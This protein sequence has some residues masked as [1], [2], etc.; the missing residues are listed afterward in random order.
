MTTDEFI[1]QWLDSRDFI[2][3]HTSGSTGAPKA[4][5]LAKADMRASARATNGFFGLTEGSLFV[6]PLSPDYIAGKM[7]IVRA[8]EAGGEI[9]MLPPSNHFEMPEADVALLAIVPSQVPWLLERGDSARVRNII[10]GGAKLDDSMRRALVDAG[11]NAYETYG[12]TETCSHVALRHVSGEVFS[13]MPGVTFSTDARGC[14]EI[15]IPNMSVK[16]VVTND[17]VELHSEKEFRWLGR[18]DNV[19]NSGGIKIFPEELEERIARLVP[20]EVCGEFYIVGRRHDVWGECVCMVFV[21]D[22]STAD[23]IARRLSAGL[24]HTHVPKVYE[25]VDALPRTSNGKIIRR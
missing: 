4:V 10:I 11:F 21:G 15:D 5:R 8:L 14:L 9:V 19:I 23:D 25:R 7:M 6:S 20:R 16:R 13:A 24:P 2:E 17:I 18:F 12:M 22:G 1:S 3:A